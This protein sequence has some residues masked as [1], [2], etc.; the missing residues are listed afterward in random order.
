MVSSDLGFPRH[1]L[2]STSRAPFWPMNTSRYAAH[3]SATTVTPLSAVFA[4]FL[5]ILFGHRFLGLFIQRDHGKQ[6][7]GAADDRAPGARRFDIESRKGRHRH[8]KWLGRCDPDKA[9]VPLG[10]VADVDRDF[11]VDQGAKARVVL[12]HELGAD[13]FL[14]LVDPAPSLGLDAGGDFE[15]RNAGGTVLQPGAPGDR[16]VIA[17]RFRSERQELMANL[18]ARSAAHEVGTEM[19]DL[20]GF[21]SSTVRRDSVAIR[22][23]DCGIDPRRGARCSQ[24]YDGTRQDYRKPSCL[25]FGAAEA[26]VQCQAERPILRE[27]HRPGLPRALSS[28]DKSNCHASL[29]CF[30]KNQNSSSAISRAEDQ[31]C[32]T[33]WLRP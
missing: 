31:P 20:V 32:C 12:D 1:L 27:F 33:V 28:D 9:E 30:C 19:A 24:Q 25:C 17:G 16:T 6:F 14:G 26:T 22:L 11:G 23:Y 4:T 18:R 29:A 10:F 7:G 8:P 13:L 15:A 21:G 5:L 3:R 2:S